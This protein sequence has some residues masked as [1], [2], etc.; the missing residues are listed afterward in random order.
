[1]PF[2]FS[3][4]QSAQRVILHRHIARNSKVL[5]PHILFLTY[6][7]KLYNL[8]HLRQ[9]IFDLT[10]LFLPELFHSTS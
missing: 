6:Y 10:Q 4:S 2:N 9:P 3:F 7:T 5:K 1:M 8:L